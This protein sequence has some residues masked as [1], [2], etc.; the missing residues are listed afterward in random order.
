MKREKA[1]RDGCQQVIMQQMMLIMLFM[2]VA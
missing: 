2:P 1:A